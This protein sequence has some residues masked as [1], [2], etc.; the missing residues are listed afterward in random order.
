MQPN[1]SDQEPRTTL[2]DGTQIGCGPQAVGISGEFVWLD[3]G[4]KVGT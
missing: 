2:S 1:N 3:D 4:S